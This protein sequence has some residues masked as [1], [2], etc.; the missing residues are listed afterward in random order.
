M[1]SKTKVLYICPFAHYSGHP[2]FAAMN[3]PK[4]LQDN[5]CEVTLLTFGGIMKGMKSKV[6]HISVVNSS[7]LHKILKIIRK[8]TLSRWL[9]MLLETTLTIRK[10]LSLRK[11]YDVLHLRDGEPFLFISH[12]LSLPFK[13]I[14]W[15]VSLTASNLYS[16]YMD[17]TKAK[18]NLFLWLYVTSLGLVNSRL[19]QPL[20]KLSMKRS[21]FI[22]MTQNEIARKGYENYLNKVFGS[23]VRC[24]PLCVNGE[25]N[26]TVDKKV[27]RK[28]LGIPKGKIVFL[29]FGA[30]HSGKD[31]ECVF[32][33]T[34][35]MKD[36]ILL[37][38][39]VQA[40]SL[41]SNPSKLAEKYRM[42][43]RV[44]VYDYYIPEA[45]K[46]YY[47]YASDALLLSYTEE[48][49]STSSMLWEAVKYRLPVISSNSNTLGNDV[50]TYSLGL[51]F[52]SSDYKS[53]KSA[54]LR[55]INMGGELRNYYSKNCDSFMKEY[56]PETWANRCK[57]IYYELQN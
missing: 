38:A 53:L 33:A 20:Y 18:E 2:P 55:Y 16:P 7:N 37:H 41:G 1:D 8:N 39:G 3:E 52:K 29:S 31:L 43:D 19:W 14:R 17:N 21:R 22:F 25:N 23:N 42:S 9:L 28:H 6:E 4:I 30:P 36:V 49:K 27:A 45:E 32:K 35:D 11:K 46:P 34:Q 15:A 47:F 44:K 26:K 48:F 51:L 57:G 5:G 10:A 12:L 50:A 40:F 54:I 13:N 56:S 24:V